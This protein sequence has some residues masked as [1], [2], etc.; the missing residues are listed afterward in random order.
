MGNKAGSIT[1]LNCPIQAPKSGCLYK[2]ACRW[3]SNAGDDNRNKQKI[4]FTHLRVL[5]YQFKNSVA[6]YW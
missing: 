4:N 6:K 1:L 5:I 2:N 3:F